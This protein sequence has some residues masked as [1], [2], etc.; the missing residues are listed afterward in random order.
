MLLAAHIAVLGYWLGADLC[1]NSEYRFI[2]HRADLAFEARDAMTD[3]LMDVDQHV[4][5]AL[6]LQVML[7]TMLAAELGFVDDRLFWF[8]PAIAALWIALIETAH[9]KRKSAIGS[10]LAR[11]DRAVRY[12]VAVLLVA[13]AIGLFFQLPD[14]LRLKLGLF[15]LLIGCG[16]VI[17][18][19]LMQ[20][21]RDWSHMRSEG[22]SPQ[23]EARI[24]ATYRRA[25]SVLLL[26]WLCVGGIAALAVFKP[27]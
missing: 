4:R 24:L 1:I 12:L 8:I 22:P 10:K 15:A 5:Y 20:H 19:M 17:R 3:H 14:W 6:V 2:T 11:I 18:F 23:Y 21:D 27:F 26:L 13:A 7:G 25:T 16:V 9:R